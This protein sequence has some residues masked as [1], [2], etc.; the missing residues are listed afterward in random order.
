MSEKRDEELSGM[1][2][3]R[4]MIGGDFRRREK[5]KGKKRKGKERIYKIQHLFD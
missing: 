2:G 1:E 3:R 5:R 4:G